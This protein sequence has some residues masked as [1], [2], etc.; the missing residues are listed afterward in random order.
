MKISR[1]VFA[2]NHLEYN[3]A[4]GKYGVQ[5][6][7]SKCHFCY[8]ANYNNDKKKNM[9]DLFVVLISVCRGTESVRLITRIKN[10]KYFPLVCFS[11]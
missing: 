8:N 10:I 3:V 6:N 5:L 1:E 4:A 7:Q 2:L 11:D 9:I